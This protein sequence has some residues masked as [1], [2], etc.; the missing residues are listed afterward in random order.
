MAIPRAAQG[1]KF[2]IPRLGVGPDEAQTQALFRTPALEVMRL[3]VR[4]GKEMPPH[5]VAKT[6]TLQCLEGCVAITAMGQTQ[7][8]RAGQILYLEGGQEH[9]LKGLEDTAI[10]LTILM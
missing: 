5:S 10:L 7:E 4:K 3:V 2:D 9:S 8:L 1:Q 6:V